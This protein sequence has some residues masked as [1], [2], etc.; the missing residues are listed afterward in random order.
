MI[1]DPE[2]LELLRNDPELL[3][4]ADAIQQT[5][6]TEQTQQ[7]LSARRRPFGRSRAG[8]GLAAC[9]AIVAAAGAFVL[10]P[11]ATAGIPGDK[12]VHVVLQR[13][14]P[15]SWLVSLADGSERQ[16]VYRDDLWI[17]ADG[18]LAL[19]E[20]SLNGHLLDTTKDTASASTSSRGPTKLSPDLRTG[21]GVEPLVGIYD[22]VQAALRNGGRLVRGPTTIFGH[23]VRWIGFDRAVGSPRMIAV[24]ADT[25]DAVALREGGDGS[26]ARIVGYT[27]S[28]RPTLPK[29]LGKPVGGHSLSV[30]RVSASGAAAALPGVLSAGQ[31][32]AGLSLKRIV[33]QRLTQ[34]DLKGSRR[35]ITLRYGQGV[36][37]PELFSPYLYISQA[38]KPEIG[39]EFPG[40]GGIGALP[41]PGFIEVRASSAPE[42][43]PRQLSAFVHV[44]GM[45][46]WIQTNLPDHELAAIVRHL[47]P[48]R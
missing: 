14:D 29:P 47:R 48:L 4:I 10:R 8:L 15:S 17:R 6:K 26:L 25:G 1:D 45:Y 39:Y 33:L 41:P 18:G 13:N 5:Q 37:L 30:A 11:A 12:Y 44:Q 16:S 22:G 28:D 46:L 20:H 19:G 3:A 38:R 36:V 32:V 34:D 40:I 7:P 21:E 23:R 24:D 9:L 35:G 31:S 27:L 2:I 43:R 42:V